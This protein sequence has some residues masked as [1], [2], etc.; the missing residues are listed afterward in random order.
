MYA[1]ET[2][3]RVFERMT[4]VGRPTRREVDALVAKRKAWPS[5]FKADSRVPKKDPVYGT[6]G[7]LKKLWHRS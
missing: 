2:A 1:K 7:P 6:Q 4:G 5:R 3:K